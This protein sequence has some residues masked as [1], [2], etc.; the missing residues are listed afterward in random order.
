MGAA[1]ASGIGQCVGGII[2][3][4]YFFMPN[5]SLLKLTK[6]KLEFKPLIKAC[7]NGSSEL[8]SN[9]SASIVGMLYNYQLLK[10]V[11]H[12]GIDSYGVLMYV[13]FIFQAISI[14]YSIGVAP[15]VSY[16][17]GSKNHQE[18]QNILKKSLWIV[19]LS[20]IFL[21]LLA[22]LS[23]V[24]LANLFVGYNHSICQ[25]T[26]HAFRLFS[27]AFI[28]SGFNIFTSSFFTALNNGSISALIS[29]LRTLI[30]QV[31]F[32]IILPIYFEL[33]GIWLSIPI[34]EIPAFIIS[35]IFLISKRKKYQYF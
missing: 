26:I 2:P 1:F 18:L 35:L 28:L 6:T 32:V 29:F 14:G 21:T 4:I 27:F 33:D 23:A 19:S 9:I 13:Q 17:L 30:F 11:G 24:P 22:Q 8:M 10:L 34:A 20:S 5:N 12:A 31:F 7:A 25:M 16:N 3:L 15:I